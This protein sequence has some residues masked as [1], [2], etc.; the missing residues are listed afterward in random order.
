MAKIQRRQFLKMAGIGLGAASLSCAGLGYLALRAPGNEVVYYEC[1]GEGMN[2]PK[3]KML[4]AYASKLGSTGGVAKAIAEELTALGMAVDV[5]RIGEAEDFS[6]YDS[7]LVGSAVRRGR[8]LPEAVDFLRENRESLASKPVSYFTVCITMHQDTPANR[9]TAQ[10]IAAPARS[11]R[12]PSAEG[13]FGG[14]M[15]YGKL[16]FMEQMILRAMKVPE[17]DYR[18][19]AAIRAWARQLPVG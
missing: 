18:D 16:S 8:W 5:K 12:E 6:R 3:G 19:W 4:I 7:V 2:N 14:L 10:G 13:F 9:A 15:D 11:I 1:E 17:G